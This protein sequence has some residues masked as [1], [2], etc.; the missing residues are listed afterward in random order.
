MQSLG[1]CFLPKPLIVFESRQYLSNGRIIESD[2]TGMP[3]IYLLDAG[4]GVQ[5][6]GTV[7]ICIMQAVIGSRRLRSDG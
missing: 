5:F 1:S 7:F 3:S 4:S 6:N 2:G